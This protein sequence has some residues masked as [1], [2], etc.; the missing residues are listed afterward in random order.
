LDSQIKQVQQESDAR[1]VAIAKDIRSLQAGQRGQVVLVGLED[2]LRM[3]RGQVP[4]VFSETVPDQAIQG[5]QRFWTMGRLANLV[6]VLVV[7]TAS[8]DSGEE[9]IRIISA[10]KATPRE[11]RFYEEIEP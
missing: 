5:K 6:V 10:R 3:G 4:D 1:A 7:H 11:R 8:D 2:A 9:V